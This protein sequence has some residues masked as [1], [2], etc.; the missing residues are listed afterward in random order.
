ML[1]SSKKAC[2][3]VVFLVEAGINWLKDNWPAIQAKAADMVQQAY[4][5]SIRH[6]RKVV[7]AFER[8]MVIGIELVEKR[9]AMPFNEA[10]DEAKAVVKGMPDEQVCAFI[11]YWFCQDA[12][13]AVAV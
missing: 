9:Q 1:E 2:S 5:M 3:W 6:L 12:A 7:V 10:L 11:A 13:Q 4:E 8:G